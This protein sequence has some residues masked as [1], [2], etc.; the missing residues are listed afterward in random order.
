MV[1]TTSLALVDTVFESSDRPLAG[2]VSMRTFC[3]GI[4]S[5]VALVILS[6]RKRIILA[7]LRHARLAAVRLED[8]PSAQ[9]KV[10]CDG[11]S[12]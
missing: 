1:C 4:S 10:G 9:G 11:F 6:R 2:R 3:G 12:C 7:A 5:T 8:T